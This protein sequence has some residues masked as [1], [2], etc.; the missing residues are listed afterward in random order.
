MPVAWCVVDVE[1]EPPLVQ[2]ICLT[3]RV[4]SVL[5]VDEDGRAQIV[6]EIRP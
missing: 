4:S 2:T 1:S 6:T 5:F 3:E